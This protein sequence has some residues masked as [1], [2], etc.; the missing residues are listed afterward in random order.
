MIDLLPLVKVVFFQYQEIDSQLNRIKVS[1][2]YRKHLFPQDANLW[3]ISFHP[4]A[5]IR[6]LA[7]L[8]PLQASCTRCAYKTFLTL[9]ARGAR[10]IFFRE[11]CLN[12]QRFFR[13][14]LRNPSPRPSSESTLAPKKR[15]WT[16]RNHESHHPST[17]SSKMLQACGRDSSCH[18]S[19]RDRPSKTSRDD[20]LDHWKTVCKPRSCTPN[21]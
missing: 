16:A 4:S 15:P 9:Y 5:I 8:N 17:A 13:F 18:E 7:S 21:V 12:Q 14:Q 1:H 3:K 19:H 20:K 11:V 2:A 6:K 10:K